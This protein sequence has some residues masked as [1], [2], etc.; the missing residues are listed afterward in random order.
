MG[1]RL[2][3]AAGVIALLGVA[4]PDFFLASIAVL[5]AAALLTVVYSCFEYRKER[6]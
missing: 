3:M 2:F 6:G 1:S 5:V 4:M